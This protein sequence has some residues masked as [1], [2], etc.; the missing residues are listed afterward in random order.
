MT[1][2]RTRNIIGQKFVNVYRTGFKY[3]YGI[4]KQ[5]DKIWSTVRRRETA[6]ARDA[7]CQTSDHTP[8]VRLPYS[9]ITNAYKTALRSTYLNT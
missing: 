2:L 3:K 1:N 8:F 4:F 9:E 7:S 6:Q 5:K